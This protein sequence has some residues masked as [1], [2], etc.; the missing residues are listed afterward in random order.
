MNSLCYCCSVGYCCC[1]FFYCNWGSGISFLLCSWPRWGICIFS[2]LGKD[3]V[4]PC[5]RHL[6]LRRWFL[7]CCTM[8]PPLYF[9]GIVWWLS[10]CRY[11]S[12]C[13]GFCTL[14]SGGIDP[15]VPF[16]PVKKS[17][18][19]KFSSEETRT[20][21]SIPFLDILITPKDDGSLQT[22]VYRKPACTDLYLQWDSHHTIPSKHCV[23]NIVPQ[24]STLTVLV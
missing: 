21:G 1:F 12:V 13:V 6:G 2:V 10:H 19:I 23:G 9:E 11:K 15:S 16:S 7:L 8:F 5:I 22:S 14:K 24:M 18:H 20:D 3:V 4:L 17:T